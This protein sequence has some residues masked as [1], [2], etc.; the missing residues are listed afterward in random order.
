MTTEF[1]DE[2]LMRFAD[3]E[4]DPDTAAQ[5]ERAMESDDELVT[6]VAM[7]METRAA[8]KDALA[9]LLEEPVPDHLTAAVERM[10]AEKKAAE[11]PREPSEPADASVVPFPRRAANDGNRAR[12]IVP[13]AASLLAALGGYWLGA[14]GASAPVGNT[15]LV[16]VSDPGLVEAL[17]TVAAGDERQLAGS[18][19]RFRAI[20]TFRD[21][22]QTLCREFELD[23]AQ[24]STVIS[25]A[26]FAD[27][28]WR[29]TFAV[30]A[31][32]DS[33]GYAP[34]SSTEA[35]DAYLQAIDAAPPMTVEEE[36]QALSSL[37]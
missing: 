23:S 17:R 35:L 5:V 29:V 27:P 1:S 3:G 6:R 9:P 32:A 24:S 31:P 18:N 19:Q 14:D 33:G 26:C 4:L 10:V 8:A 37:R 13:I 2:I 28:G 34:A 12:W 21:N 11:G 7:F 15:D 30:V 20:A 25:V 16:A 36:T 22:A